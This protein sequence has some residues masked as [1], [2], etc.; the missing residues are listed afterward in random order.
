MAN[1]GRTAGIVRESRRQARRPARQQIVK[2]EMRDRSTGSRVLWL[3]FSLIMSSEVPDFASGYARSHRLYEG[4]GIVVGLSSIG[5]LAYRL[6]TAET[7]SGWWIPLTVFAG[8]LGADF[9]S[10]FVHW[11][12]DTW[13]STRTPVVGQLAIRTFR[14]HHVDA[15][16]MTRHGFVETNGHNITLSVVPSLTGGFALTHHTLPYALVAMAC[17]FMAVCVAMTSQIHKWAHMQEAPRIVRWFQDAG[18]IIGARHHQRH[19]VMPHDSNYCITVGWM[20]APLELVRFFR[21]LERVITAVTGVAPRAEDLA[22]TMAVR[23]NAGAAPFVPETASVEPP[24]A[25]DVVRVDV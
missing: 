17:F 21:G 20:N 14:E 16:A 4:A 5:V 6:G 13:G 24:D 11:F 9:T 23:A 25:A 22:A 12:F 8:L 18:L 3:R 19:H 10:G 1:P 2:Q 7:V 15:R